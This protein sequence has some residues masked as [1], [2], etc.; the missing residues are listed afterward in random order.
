MSEPLGRWMTVEE[1]PPRRART[2]K[3]WRVLGSDQST[4]GQVEWYPRWR[5]YVFVPLAFGEGETILN[6]GC[7]A[8]LSRFCDERTKAHLGG[9]ADDKTQ[10]RTRVDG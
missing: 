9:R 1:A 2:T 3:L 8:D 4:L 5:Q 10:E 7:L 6:H